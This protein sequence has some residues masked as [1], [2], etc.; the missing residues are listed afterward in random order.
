MRTPRHKTF[1]GSPTFPV[2]GNA[3]RPGEE[4]GIYSASSQDVS[5]RARFLE[6]LDMLTFKRTQVRAPLARDSRRGSVLIIVL[7]IIFG[8][9]S[10]TLYFANSMT[11]ELRASD[12]QV[13]GIEAE[14]AIEGARRYVSLVLSNLNVAGSIPDPQ[15]YQAEAVPVG[16]A[17]F[18]LI[19]RTNVENL[20]AT[21]ATFG[22]I[23]EAS[24]V[25]LNTASSNML[26]LLPRMTPDLVNS[27]LAWRSTNTANTTGGAESDTY[28]RL[29]PPYL[30]KNAPFETVD[31]LRLI[32]NMDIDVLYGEDANLNGMLE[33]NENDGDVLPPSDNMD[34]RLDPGILEYV[35]VYTHEPTTGT[36]GSARIDV[37][38]AA[39]VT[40]LRTLLGQLLGTA[41]ANQI[42][43]QQGGGGGG[44]PTFSSPL[45]FYYTSGLTASEFAQVEDSIRGPS[46][47]GLINV[48]TASSTVLAG[49]PGMDINKATQLVGYRQ[50][51]QSNQNNQD[52]IA[53]VKQVLDQPTATQMGRYITGKSYQFTADIAAVGHNGRGYRRV[54]FVFD[55][56]QGAPIVV[57]RQDLTHL[58]WALGKQVR[59]KWLLAKTS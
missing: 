24:K 50:A 20:P 36:N 56:S 7:W 27:I 43:P 8:L 40:Q 33:P 3:S 51:N 38:T 16:N 26:A 13:A 47:Q 15:V 58:G 48:N 25:N 5:D 46:L 11:F 30:C 54:R 23:D 21:T 31:E 2:N 6:R 34:G 17:H 10:L 28:M 18:W 1:S 42:I 29:Q 35:T 52:T 12:N 22:L 9:I 49:L 41:R 14:Q 59:D 32:Y 44:G 4:R 19:G 55:L 57:H 39:G 37:T 45:Q 53:W